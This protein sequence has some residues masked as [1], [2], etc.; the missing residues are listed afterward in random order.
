MSRKGPWR[1]ARTFATQIGMTN[2][3]LKKQG[4]ISVK[5]LWVNKSPES[6]LF[7]VVTIW[8]FRSLSLTFSGKKRTISLETSARSGFSSMLQIRCH[9]R[10]LVSRFYR[11][12][13][14]L[15]Y[16]GCEPIQ[17]HT[18]V[19]PFLKPIARHPIPIRTEYAGY[20]LPTR[21][22]E[23]LGCEGFWRHN[24]Y[25]SLASLLTRPGN[26]EKH[27]IKSSVICDF[28][29]HQNPFLLFFLLCIVA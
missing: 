1:L 4:L 17:N 11:F 20:F 5:E 23:R 12:F 21:L 6:G 14:N 29:I 28:T 27:F 9:F 2:Q 16:S 26:S 22:N 15:S 3:W 25:F 19:S 7:R 18:I 24:L 8:V 13:I 10:C